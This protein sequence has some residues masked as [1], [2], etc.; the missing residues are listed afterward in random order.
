CPTGFVETV[1][2]RQA[3]VVVRSYTHGRR[4]ISARDAGG[5]HFY[6]YDAIGSVRLLTGDNWM[7]SDTYDYDAFGNLLH[8]SG[9]THNEFRFKGERL[10]PD[11]NLVFLRARYMKPSTGRFM[12]VDPALEGNRQRPITFNK[13]LFASGNAVDR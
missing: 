1:E 7:I 9:I 8:S 4:L 5:N 3:G 12:T 2:E 13:Y 6:H 11:L 10:D